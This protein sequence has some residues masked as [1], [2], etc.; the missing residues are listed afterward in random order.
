M[1]VVVDRWRRKH[2]VSGKLVPSALDG[3]GLP[4]RAHVQDVDFMRGVVKPVQ[5]RQGE[6]LKSETSRTPVPISSELALEL[7]AAV[8]RWGGDRVVTDGAGH[9]TSTWAI[10]R[11]VRARGGR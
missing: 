8:A 9:Q 3:K 5:Q 7:S 6:P 11:A 1:A 2:R 4:Y 10:E